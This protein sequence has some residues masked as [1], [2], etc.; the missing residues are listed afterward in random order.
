MKGILL[1]CVVS[2]SIFVAM[3]ACFASWPRL[4]HLRISMLA[5]AVSLVVLLS[6]YV[7][8]PADLGILPDALIERAAWLDV[9]VAL[10][11]LSASFFGGWLQ[12]YNLT[13][14]GYSLR[15]LVDALHAPWKS[16]TPQGVVDGYADGRGLTWMYDIRMNGLL[17]A[18]LL[19]DANGQL[20]LTIRG[21][22][23]ARLFSWLR[24]LYVV[25]ETRD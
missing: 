1:A 13:S 5:F 25:G 4:S 6:L 9:L 22:N 19:N 16:T 20:A 14:R 3:T 11:V 15:I 18:G 21:R 17:Q 8:T 7:L 23:A 10:F 12:L 24:K 2:V